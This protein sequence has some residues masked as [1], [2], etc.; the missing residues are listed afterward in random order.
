MEG[1]D[2]GYLTTE[3]KE[4]VTTFRSLSDKAREYILFQLKLAKNG[5]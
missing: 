2:I 1:N 3:E 4:L 5:E